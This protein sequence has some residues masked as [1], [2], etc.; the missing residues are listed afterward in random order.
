MA[1]ISLLRKSHTLPISLEAA[2]AYFSDPANLPEITPPDLGFKVLSD[3]PGS[4]Y[5]GMILRYSVRPLPGLSTVWVSEITHV[6]D[7]E[8]F[9][10][11]QRIGPYR[12]WHHEHHFRRDPAGVI[13]ED[14]VHYALPFGWL[15]SLLAGAMVRRRLE[16]I[17]AYRAR[18]LIQRFGNL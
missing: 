11:E 3:P 5:P 12:L 1:S 9:V 4:I 17:F 15:G 8:F 7:L 16:A 14:I 2:W 10:D 6:R 13:V 18:I